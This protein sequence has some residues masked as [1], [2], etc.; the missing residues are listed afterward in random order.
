MRRASLLLLGPPLLLLSVVVAW[1]WSDSYLTVRMVGHHSEGGTGA[2]SWSSDVALISAGGSVAVRRTRVEAERPRPLGDRRGPR[3]WHVV[4]EQ[5]IGVSAW[6][7]GLGGRQWR[8]LGFGAVSGG[9]SQN[10]RVEV[11]WVPYWIVL[12]LAVVPGLVWWS[13]MRRRRLR[14]AARRL[15]LCPTCGYDLRA[16][17]GQC[18]E[19]GTAASVTANG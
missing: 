7:Q 5:G 18:P 19:C 2:T 10:D 8:W 16:T 4:V 3:G 14:R 1:L 15:G 9:Y 11:L 17:P 13:A 6:R 12:A